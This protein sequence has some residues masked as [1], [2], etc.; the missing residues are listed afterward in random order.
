MWG[1]EFTLTQIRFTSVREDALDAPK[2]GGLALL[3]G[4]LIRALSLCQKAQLAQQ[5][6]TQLSDSSSDSSLLRSVS[7]PS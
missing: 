7:A 5:S 6:R 3:L 2:Y 4:H 1:L